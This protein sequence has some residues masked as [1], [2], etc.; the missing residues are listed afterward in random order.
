MPQEQKIAGAK[1]PEEPVIK[2]SRKGTGC[3]SEAVIV[4]SGER[5]Q[6]KDHTA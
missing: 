5:R 1:R 2:G 3:G 4:A 6:G